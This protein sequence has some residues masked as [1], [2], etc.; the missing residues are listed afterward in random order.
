MIQGVGISLPIAVAVLDIAM[1]K[2]WLT[3]LIAGSSAST[4]SARAAMLISPLSLDARTVSPDVDDDALELAMAFPRGLLSTASLEGAPR[5]PAQAVTTAGD[6]NA[7]AD[8][9]SDLPVNG[10]MLVAGVASCEDVRSRRKEMQ[11]HL[12]GLEV[13][14][15]V[16]A[17][18][19]RGPTRHR[20]Q[21][22]EL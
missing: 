10:R 8:G 14:Q 2:E 22:I 17:S 19:M 4:G 7:R 20:R 9:S 16:F 11:T 13:I 21:S 3:R 1:R 5:S 15:P 6:D 12:E 18:P